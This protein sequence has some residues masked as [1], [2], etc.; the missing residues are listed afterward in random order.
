VGGGFF[1]HFTMLP[2]SFAWSAFGE[3]N[4]A[5]SEQ[6]LRSRVEKYRR[7]SAGIAEDYLICC[8]LLQQ[9]FFFD[10][11]DWIPVPSWARS[12]VRGKGYSTD[13]PDG[14]Q[15]WGKVQRILHAGRIQAEPLA[16]EPRFGDP[17]MIL[18]RLGQGAFRV[19]VTDGYDRR[20]A[21]T[22]SHVLHVLEAAH[23]K[24]YSVGGTHQPT[25]G[26]LLRQDVHTLFDRGYLTVTPE[27]QVEISKRLKEEFDNGKEYYALHGAQIHLPQPPH[28]RP[29]QESLIWHN[30][31]VFRP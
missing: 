27:Y 22:R 30:E 23:I 21:L 8:I 11:A 18:P 24:P 4:G 12:I 26:I 1:S 29:S 7:V 17:T 13:Q 15:L 5:A 9:P 31:R 20:C 2:A 10:R 3:K 6:E 19:I 28:L 25:N 16:A 14:A